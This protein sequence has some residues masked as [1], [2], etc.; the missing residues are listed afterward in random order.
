MT[1]YTIKL[2]PKAYR[3]ID[4][5]Y[6]Y[7]AA[8]LQISNISEKLIGDFEKAI[9]SLE[10]LPYRGSERKVGNYANKGYR[11]IFIKN[12]TIIYRIDEKNKQVLVVTVRYTPCNF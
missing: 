2:L 6:L 8:K 3:D 12:F 9:L 10:E 5:I 11:Q 4:E 7:I 1:K